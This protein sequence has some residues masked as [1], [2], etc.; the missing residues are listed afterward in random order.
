M[1]IGFRFSFPGHVQ[2]GWTDS[3]DYV[4]HRIDSDK[5][6]KYEVW[7]GETCKKIEI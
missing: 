7:D 1:I 2:E 5:P 6:D 4:K 3:L